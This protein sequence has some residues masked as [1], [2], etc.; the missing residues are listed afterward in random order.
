VSKG[1]ELSAAISDFGAA[2]K[3]KLANKAATGAPEDQLRAP[4]ERLA[5]SDPRA[6]SSRAGKNL[7]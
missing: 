2:A 3:R 7:C 1:H 5:L 6:P 4:L